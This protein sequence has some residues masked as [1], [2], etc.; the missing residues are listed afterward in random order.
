MSGDLGGNSN[1]GWSFPDASS[2]QRPGN[3][4]FWYWRTS[5]W[6]WA[7][8][9]SSWNMNVG[10][11][12]NCGTCHIC[13]MSRYVKPVTVLSAKKN[14]LYTFWLEIAQNT[15]PLGKSRWCSTQACG[16]SDPHILTLRRFTAQL[17]W[18]VASSLNCT[19]CRKWSSEL[20]KSCNCKQK[21]SRRL[22]SSSDN[23]CT[24][25]M[26]YVLNTKRLC[27]TLHAVVFD[28]DSSLAAVPVNFFG[29]SRKMARS[30]STSSSAVNGRPLDFYLH[31]HPV[32]V[33]V[34]STNGLVCMRV[35]CVL[36]MK[37]TLHSNHRL[38]TCD[39]PIHRTSFTGS[40]HFLTTDTRIA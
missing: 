8:L 38:N 2:I 37:C 30:R 6:K 7:G 34:P 12:C 32:S 24:I 35:L 28:T 15:L 19:F 20:I 13:N 31:R 26:R 5:Q 36:C 3:T 29:L 22:W 18:N 4:V 23:C 21:S 10:M 16:F 39:I 33:Q 14:G 27:R 11:F 9:P 1:S 25:S 17:T 40:S